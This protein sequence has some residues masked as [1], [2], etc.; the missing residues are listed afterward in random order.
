MDHVEEYIDVIS[1]DG[2]LTGVSK[3]RSSV[4]QE[5]DWHRSVHVWILNNTHELLIQRRAF[6]KENHPGLWDVSC[7]GHITA[8]DSS[9]QAAV[10]ELKEE[11]GLTIQPDALERMF[12]IESHYVLNDGT[13]I[14]NELVDVY[15]LRKNIY[16]NSLTLQSE[17][18]DS[19]KAISVDAFR[20]CVLSKDPSFVPFWNAYEKLLDYLD[21]EDRYQ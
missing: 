18:V 16:L 3:P 8:G 20:K 14:D 6:E 7:A 13:Y 2:D 19:I 10:R 11:L 15:L 1:P 12:T 17:E 4:H 9:R 5:G 21:K